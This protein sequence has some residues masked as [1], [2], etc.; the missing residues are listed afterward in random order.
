M[1]RSLRLDTAVPL[2]LLGRWLG[3]WADGRSP[4][5]IARERVSFGDVNTPL[6]AYVYRGPGEL[7]GV[8][9]VAPGLHFLGADDPR[10]D[11][12]CRILAS[13]GFLVLTPFVRS[14]LAL[15][16]HPSAFDDART[17]FL[18]AKRLAD[19]HGLARPAVFSISFGSALA[20]DIAS[21]PETRRHVG[22]VLVFG[23]FADFLATVRFA[24][25]GQTEFEGERLSLPHDPLNAPV[26]YL[27]ALPDLA[28]EGDRAEL[29]D[30][31]HR[32]VRRT[33]NRPELK[34]PGARDPIAHAIAGGLPPELRSPFL[35]GCG[36]E[37][38]G[39]AWLEATLARTG[40]RLS[41]LE[42]RARLAD[43]E[44]PVT[45]VHGRNDD[46]IAYVEA[47]KLARALPAGRLRGHYLTGL[48]GHTGQERVT[49]RAVASEVRALGGMLHAL[50]VS[51]LGD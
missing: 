15:E 18:E 27:N 26:V 14:Y 4:A 31:W 35:M 9:Y 20:F 43:V 1:S 37:P 46:V 45:L 29:A 50:A 44:A 28:L 21:H 30:A 48:Y 51:A 38:G 33:W 40:E 12:F 22:G 24:V 23:G 36:L 3:P 16:L 7:R 39:P 13:A 47:T 11:R 17:A 49:A 41:F 10:F 2:A 6:E 34:L 42:P 8:Y 19:E 5:R 32:M 25:T